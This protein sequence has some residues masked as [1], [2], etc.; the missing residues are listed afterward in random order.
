[1]SDFGS[2]GPPPSEADLAGVVLARAAAR[3]AVTRAFETY[4]SALERAFR[5]EL[6]A[7][8]RRVSPVL[9]ALLE[10]EGLPL[11][12]VVWSITPG[13]GW[14]FRPLSGATS[15]R[16]GG[17]PAPVA[18]RITDL[19]LRLSRAG[20][21]L[22]L[23]EGG[24]IR[25]EVVDGALEVGGRIGTVRVATRGNV[26]R[27]TVPG[28]V[29]RAVAFAAVGHSAD[30]LVDLAILRGRDWPVTA[31]EVG[32]PRIGSTFVVETGSRRCVLP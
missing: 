1:M 3:L 4:G 18:E 6:G 27:L 8:V 13:L 7:S 22:R 21:V 32:R 11:E 17:R 31:V 30:R 12:E 2:D 28:T 20:T 9:L 15:A 10:R 5:A 24:R 19:R 29:P 23:Y 26:A 14:P 16:K 25:I